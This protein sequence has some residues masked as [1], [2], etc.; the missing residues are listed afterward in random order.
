MIVCLFVFREQSS[1]DSCSDRAGYLPREGELCSV[2]SAEG[3]GAAQEGRP[4][5]TIQQCHTQ[6]H[7]RCRANSEFLHDCFCVLISIFPCPGL[8]LAF[9]S[10]TK[11]MY[12][13]C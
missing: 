1:A 11:L 12:K 4:Q 6:E 9:L 8:L 5:A 10:C 3:P 13:H 2:A 7:Q